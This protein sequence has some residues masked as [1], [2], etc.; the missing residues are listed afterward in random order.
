MGWFPPPRP[1]IVTS[2]VRASGM[3][4]SWSA[5]SA[6]LW[7]GVC[8]TISLLSSG[9]TVTSGQSIRPQQERI[10]L[11]SGTASCFVGN[12]EG[13]AAMAVGFS[14]ALGCWEGLDGFL[15]FIILERCFICEAVEG[16]DQLRRQMPK[17]VDTPASRSTT[18][19]E[20]QHFENHAALSPLSGLLTLHVYHTTF[21]NVELGLDASV[22]IWARIFSLK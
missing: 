9:G 13:P 10:C 19:S 6:P 17:V 18:R 12:P 7:N 5:S 3:S 1:Q 15:R 8:G 14:A 2:D 11:P 20:L 4:G 16:C 22:R 21:Q